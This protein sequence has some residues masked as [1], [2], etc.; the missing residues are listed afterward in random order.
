MR[1]KSID[2]DLYCSVHLRA[3]GRVRIFING[4]CSASA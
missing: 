3:L 4:R 2:I 1:L